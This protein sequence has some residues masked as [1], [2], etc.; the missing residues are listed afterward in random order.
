[1]DAIFFSAVMRLTKPS[2][3]T[4]VPFSYDVDNLEK[5]EYSA[6][7]GF[8]TGLFLSALK[9]ML[10]LHKLSIIFILKN[11]ATELTI[12]QNAIALL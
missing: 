4:T 10:I 11:H 3:L 8:G 2:L 12:Y 7:S 6:D 5:E 1:M 9:I